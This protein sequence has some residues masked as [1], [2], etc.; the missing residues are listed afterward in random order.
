MK[1]K[2]KSLEVFSDSCGFGEQRGYI[3][4]F[5]FFF[6]VCVIPGLFILKGERRGI[7]FT[8]VTKS[9]VDYSKEVATERRQELS[10][11]QV[12]VIHIV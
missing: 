3:Q 1:T 8:T 7:P 11:M 12:H 10:D 9:S 4:C 2:K 5:S 6:C